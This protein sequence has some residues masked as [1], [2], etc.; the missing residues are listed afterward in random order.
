MDTG[1]E[2]LGQTGGRAFAFIGPVLPPRGGPAA[3]RLMPSARMLRR[4]NAEGQE[5]GW[6]ESR[7]NGRRGRPALSARA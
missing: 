7:P 6:G 4:G 5:G 3:E 1:S 2:G